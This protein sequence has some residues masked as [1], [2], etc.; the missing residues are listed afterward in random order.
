MDTI[1]AIAR[2]LI[3]PLVGNILITFQFHTGSV[4]DSMKIIIAKSFFVFKKILLLLLNQ[5]IFN[6]TDLVVYL[7]G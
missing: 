5:I 1:Y 4:V 7:T 6:I 3:V 2:D